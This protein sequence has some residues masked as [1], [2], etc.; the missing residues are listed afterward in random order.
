M[1]IKNLRDK[2]LLPDAPKWL[3]DNII[4]LTITGSQAY[5]TA[6][7]SNSLGVSDV[8]I[9]GI[10]I[11]KK[12]DLFPHLK[13]YIYNFGKKP[14]YFEQYQKH[15]IKDESSNKEYDFSI[16]NIVKFFNLLM[17]NNPTCIDALFTPHECVLHISSV[18]NYLRDNRK[19]FLHKGCWAK[20]KGYS[21]S[22]VHKMNSKEPVEG[23]KRAALRELHGFD[24]KYA[25]HL[26]RLLG[27]AEQILVEGDLDIRRNNEHLKAIRRGEV[28]REQILSWASEKEKQL[29]EAYNKS[30]LPFGP[31]EEEIKK[32][33]MECLEMHYGS[34]DKVI[35]QPDRYETTLRMIK[36]ELDKLDF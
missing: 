32:L 10:C 33:L 30:T 9:Y 20:F 21:Y 36:N 8:D 27:E 19:K 12:I 18:G 6:D 2:N 34:L 1:I 25:M 3:D 28:S 29:E 11:P 16:Y 24:T 14:N 23:S 26:V 22:M 35:V 7:T 15:H 13:G 17:E 4:Y 5:G 31:N